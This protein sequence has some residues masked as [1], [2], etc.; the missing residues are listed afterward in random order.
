MP[1]VTL[2]MLRKFSEASSTLV[3]ADAPLFGVVTLFHGRILN[4]GAHEAEKS[5]TSLG[6]PARHRIVAEATRFWVQHDNGVRECKTREQMS[7]LLVERQLT[8]VAR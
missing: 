4:R 2:E 1:D 5:G 6:F 3:T 8:A 7:S